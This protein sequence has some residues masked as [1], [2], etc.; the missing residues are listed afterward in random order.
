MGRGPIPGAQAHL[1]PEYPVRARRSIRWGRRL[2]VV[3]GKYPIWDPSRVTRRRVEVEAGQAEY[4][5]GVRRILRPGRR[6]RLVCG[7]DSGHLADVFFLLLFQASRTSALSP[8]MLVASSH[9][10]ILI[11]SNLA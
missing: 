4:P 8:R 7:G 10:P 6:L 3:S 1:R 9:A 5:A 2:R 11:R